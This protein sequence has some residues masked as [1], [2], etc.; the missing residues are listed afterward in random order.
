VPQE[1]QL[2]DDLGV[3]PAIGLRRAIAKQRHRRA[4]QYGAAI[5]ETIKMYRLRGAVQHRRARGSRRHDA[6]LFC[7][8]DDQRDSVELVTGR[9]EK[10]QVCLSAPLYQRSR[11]IPTHAVTPRVRVEFSPCL[12]T[13]ARLRARPSTLEGP[14]PCR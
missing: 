14:C 6:N 1:L 7:A 4:D 5:I 11:R 10:P 13:D 3:R 8:L 9:V 12:R 2:L